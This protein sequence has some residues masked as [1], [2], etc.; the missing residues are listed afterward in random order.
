MRKAVRKRLEKAAKKG[1]RIVIAAT[2][3][4]LVLSNAG[5]VQ[6]AGIEDVFDEQYYADE[7]P[8]LK[9]VYGNARSVLLNHFIRAGLLEGRRM[10]GLIDIVKYK[11]KYPDL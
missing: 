2:V 8:E 10:N 1:R 3:G 4:A 7:Y 11:E 6:A 5:Y 9:D